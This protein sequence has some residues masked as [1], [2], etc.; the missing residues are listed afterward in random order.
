MRPPPVVVGIRVV[1]LDAVRG[2]E[3]AP[4]GRDH[5]AELPDRERRVG[6]VLEHLAAEN[7]L[8]AALGHR[9][10]LDGSFELCRRIRHVDTHVLGDC[11]GEEG[12]VRLAPAPDVE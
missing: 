2:G 6:C 12:L 10:R 11:A 7:E 5:A 9:N 3:H 8:E 4:A 1:D